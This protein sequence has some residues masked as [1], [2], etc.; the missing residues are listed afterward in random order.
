MLKKK[1]VRCQSA[2]GR[3]TYS[4]LSNFLIEPTV[5]VTTPTQQSN[6]VVTTVGVTNS[7]DGV[8]P[9]ASLFSSLDLGQPSSATQKKPPTPFNQMRRSTSCHQTE[10]EKEQTL[11]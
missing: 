1:F 11:T 10:Q 2:F 4:K 6:H 7:Q 5:S 9:I 8:I 3:L